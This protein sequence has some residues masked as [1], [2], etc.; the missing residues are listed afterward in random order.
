VND[1]GAILVRVYQRCSGRAGDGPDEAS[2]RQ[3]TLR[4]T[5]WLVIGVMATAVVGMLVTADL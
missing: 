2:Y 4:F 3:V 1:P 5:E